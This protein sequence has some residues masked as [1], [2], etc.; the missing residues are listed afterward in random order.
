MKDCV[1]AFPVCGE[2]RARVGRVEYVL[3]LVECWVLGRV[4]SEDSETGTR[5]AGEGEKRGDNGPARMKEKAILVAAT[6]GWSENAIF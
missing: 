2:K 5:K 3:R 1:M 6:V 4:R